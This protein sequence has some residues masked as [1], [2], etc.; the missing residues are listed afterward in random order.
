MFITNGEIGD[1][2]NIFK[3]ILCFMFI[4]YLVLVNMNGTEFKNILCFMFISLSHLM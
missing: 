1:M 4:A 3:N 2:L